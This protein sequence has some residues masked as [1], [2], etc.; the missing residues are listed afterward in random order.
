MDKLDSGQ[1]DYKFTVQSQ[2]RKTLK[3]CSNYDKNHCNQIYLIYIKYSQNDYKFTVQSQN[4][5][6]LKDYT[7]YDKKSL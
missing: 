7:N 4:C 2:N 6:P 1:N 5:K 3:D